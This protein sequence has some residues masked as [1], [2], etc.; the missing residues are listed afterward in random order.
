MCF[1]TSVIIWRLKVGQLVDMHC[2]VLPGIDDGSKSM[3][4]SLNMVKIAASEGIGTMILTPHFHP[5]KGNRDVDKWNETVNALKE[6]VRNE[7]IEMDFHLG[8]ELFYTHDVPEAIESG[9]AITMAG[10]DYVLLEFRT[11][12][13]Y[14]YIKSAAYEISAIGKIPIIAHIERYDCLVGRMERV[15]E[16]IDNGALIQINASSI[17]GDMGFK[18]KMYLKKL[19]KN[20]LVDFISTDAHSDGR[21]SPRIAECFKYISKKYGE[22]YALLLMRDNAL[23][24]INNTEI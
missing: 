23:K 19:L 13:E 20:Q 22:A 16:L 18:M 21:R 3:E 11:E 12:T 9:K 7:G 24:V 14:S 10:S 2:H 5:G 6:A 1:E 8:S 4:Q 15:E 17:T